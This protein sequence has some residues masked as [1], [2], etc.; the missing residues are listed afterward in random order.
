LKKSEQVPVFFC[1]VA[2]WF[3]LFLVINPAKKSTHRV[4][5]SWWGFL[6]EKQLTSPCFILSRKVVAEFVVF[7]SETKFIRE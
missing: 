6:I 3:F 2:G 1:P 4:D 7:G 5:P